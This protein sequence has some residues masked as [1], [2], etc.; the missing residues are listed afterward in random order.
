[1]TIFLMLW[2][3]L[4]SWQNVWCHDVFLTSWQTVWRRGVFFT[5]WTNCLH[6]DV[7][8]TLWLFGLMT[9]PLT[10]CLSSWHNSSLFWEQ[11]IIK[12]CFWCYSELFDVIACFWCYD[13]LL[14]YFWHTFW[15][16]NVVF[17]LYFLTIWRIFDVMTNLFDVMTC[18]SHYHMFLTS[19]Q[20]FWRYHARFDVMTSLSWVDNI[21]MDIINQMH[22]N[23]S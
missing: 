17:L 3:A 2:H 5:F 6:H 1:M 11:N 22:T 20:T 9:N 19:W 4:M 8:L 23:I 21:D 13:E 10:R 7:Y 14:A 16:H 12:T 18:F 15:H